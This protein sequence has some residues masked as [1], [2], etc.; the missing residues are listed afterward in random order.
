MLI[1]GLAALDSGLLAET[2]ALFEKL[3]PTLRGYVLS[4][5]ERGD[6]G[7]PLDD[8]ERFMDCLV[9]TVTFAFLNYETGIDAF[10]MQQT[11]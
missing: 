6:L 4:A 9:E 1:E 2:G 8:A 5:F 11:R 7:F 10:H 3:S